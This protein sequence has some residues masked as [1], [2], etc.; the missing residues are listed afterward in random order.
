MKWKDREG[1]EVGAKEFFRRWREGIEGI[2]PLQ[3]ASATYKNTWIM[4]IGLF[5]GFL[6]SVWQIKNLWWLSIILAAAL[7]NTLIMQIGNYQ[8]Y[9][10]LKRMEEAFK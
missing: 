7:M 5:L 1:K 2:T 10:A 9:K 6:Y 3:Q 4:I 8:K